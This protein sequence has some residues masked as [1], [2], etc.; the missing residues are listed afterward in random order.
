M[1]RFMGSPENMLYEESINSPAWMNE[2]FKSLEE[3]DS[4]QSKTYKR[5]K[6]RF[7]K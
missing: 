7:L 4:T 3:P 5:E 1:Y 6:K 2:F